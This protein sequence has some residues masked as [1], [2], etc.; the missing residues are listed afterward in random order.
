MSSVAVIFVNL[1]QLYLLL[2]FLFGL[3]FVFKGVQKVD[4]VADHTS[5]RF[6]LLI[7]PGT[8]ALWPILLNKWI[9]KNRS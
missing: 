2:G 7:L 1:F 6:R 9:K 3:F 4:P 8:M 5:W